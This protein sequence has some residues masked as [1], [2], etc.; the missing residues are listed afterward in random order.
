M[1]GWGAGE[2]TASPTSVTTLLVYPEQSLDLSGSVGL[3]GPWP[4][5]SVKQ[6]FH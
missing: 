4:L 3:M 2:L 1:A 6:S 5:L